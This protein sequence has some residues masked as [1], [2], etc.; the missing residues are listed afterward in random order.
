MIPTRKTVPT[1]YQL[2]LAAV[3][4]EVACAPNLTVWQTPRNI[5]V[6]SGDTVNITC[7]FILKA[8]DR[9]EVK[10]RWWKHDNT[11]NFTQ[12]YNYSEDKETSLNKSV[13]LKIQSVDVGNGGVYHCTVFQEVPTL[14]KGRDKQGTELTVV[15][16]VPTNS[17]I[18]TSSSQHHV[19]IWTSVLITVCII[20]VTYIISRCRHTRQK[21]ER[22]HQSVQDEVLYAKL[23]IPESQERRNTHAVN[24]TQEAETTSEV[25]Y[26]DIR[27]KF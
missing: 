2:L 19:I 10:V 27:V 4:T 18:I 23:N 26:S 3:L 24:Q 6:L 14:R 1:V 8:P 13:T 7:H 25:L 20:S 16:V 21:Q 12:N 15:F 22:E 11:F 9:A 5:S 17:S